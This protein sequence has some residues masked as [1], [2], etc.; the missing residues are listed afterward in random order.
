[1]VPVVW[2]PTEGGWGGLLGSV[3]FCAHI[4]GVKATEQL[5]DFMLRGGTL[6]SKCRI[7][8]RATASRCSHI[9][10]ICQL[11]SNVLGAMYCQPCLINSS[12]LRSARM[13]SPVSMIE[14]GVP[15]FEIS[16]RA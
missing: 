1:M 14:S 16:D 11:G 8:P 12:K 15:S 6:I 13:R 9:A 4:H 2:D 7:S 10:S 5:I 3:F